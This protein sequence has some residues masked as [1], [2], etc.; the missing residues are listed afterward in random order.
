M[1]VDVCN[2]NNH[3]SN[4]NY[5]TYIHSL[6]SWK[7]YINTIVDYNQ[8]GILNLSNQQSNKIVSSKKNPKIRVKYKTLT[9]KNSYSLLTD[10]SEE[11]LEESR[12][13]ESDLLND[14][15]SGDDQSWNE[16]YVIPDTGATATCL[17]LN[18]K[19]QNKNKVKDG[20]WV[21]SCTETITTAIATGNL[22]L[23]NLS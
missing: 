23:K 22:L 5:T 19:L 12:K 2:E 3:S 13:G 11:K 4:N 8:I 1:A 15:D 9:I 7:H 16:Q 10:N 14:N 20:M 21:Q 17:I 18:T 6:P